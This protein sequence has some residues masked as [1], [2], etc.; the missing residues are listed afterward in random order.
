MHMDFKNAELAID[1]IWIYN[2]LRRNLFLFTELSL[3]VLWY[4]PPPLLSLIRLYYLNK[5]NAR[6]RLIGCAFSAKIVFCWRIL[7]YVCETLN[8][9]THLNNSKQFNSRLW[10]VSR[11][12]HS[13]SNAIYANSKDFMKWEAFNS[14][15]STY[16]C[17]VHN[18]HTKL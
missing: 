9:E 6:F 1:W 18:L 4:K 5:K 2:M 17:E 10:R 11:K 16:K 13:F 8:H 12:R 3:L 15:S 7:N 14:L